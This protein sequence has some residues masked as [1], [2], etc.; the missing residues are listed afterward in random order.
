MYPNEPRQD[1]QGRTPDP[2]QGP[3]TAAPWVSPGT[4]GGPQQ[5]QQ[6][7]APQQAAPE[8]HSDQT[9]GQQPQAPDQHVQQPGQAS[10][11]VPPPPYQQHQPQQH[12]PQH[13]PAGQ[14]PYATQ[15]Q[16]THQLYPSMGGHGAP[17]PSWPVG[18]VAMPEPAP[19]RSDRR[20][21]PLV[22]TAAGAALVA[23][24]ATTGILVGFD[25][26]AHADT[27]IASLGATSSEAVPVSGSTVANPD[28][29]KVA[30]AVRPSVV[31]IKVQIS[32]G[33]AEGS[34]VIVD[35]KGHILTNNH[36]VA[37]AQQGGI[38]VTLSD[39][40]V[41]DATVAGTDPTT[42]LAVI[43]LTNPPSDLVPA[44]LGDSS[45]VVVGEPVMA[46]GN[47]LGLSSTV[48]TGIVSALDRPVS[49]SDG[50]SQAV[51]TNAIQIDAAINPGNSGGPLFNAQG[52]VV[53]ITSSI[54]SLSQ[55]SGSIGLG[56]AIPSNLANRI[57]AELLADGTASH[58]FLGVEL[59][60]GEATADGVTRMGAQIHSVSPGTPAASAG[61]KAGDVIVA[62]DGNPV[63]GAES[64]TGYV[65]ALAAGQS[66]TLTVV[67]DGK[68][69]TV[70]VTFAALDSSS[71]SGSQQGQS[72]SLPSLPWGQGG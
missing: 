25:R 72:P 23:S 61:L 52:E 59:T 58:A 36:V 29:E 6:A 11:P 45:K 41:F 55:S 26:P 33:E 31:A 48:T 69:F 64:L 9:S 16:P 8:G 46:V 34:G 60:D 1:P 14:H 7:A 71:T 63:S 20:W 12:Q 56:F 21:L 35:T 19:R 27:S 42:D 70:D 62:I 49:T 3:R 13:Q 17:P 53:G 67:R 50:S 4:P 24:V 65:R 43:T 38:S 10:R 44:V 32:G 57:G 37:D 30:E 40:R 47:P 51:V 66:A 18:Q 5:G 15:H 68:S 2:Q 22:A 54:A 28:W 39:G